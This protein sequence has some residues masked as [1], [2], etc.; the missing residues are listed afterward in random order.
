[1]RIDDTGATLIADVDVHEPVP[2]LNERPDTD[3]VVFN[4]HRTLLPRNYDS[5]FLIEVMTERYQNAARDQWA[6]HSL[7]LMTGHRAQTDKRT[8][9]RIWRASSVAADVYPA[10]IALP[11]TLAHAYAPMVIATA[12]LAICMVMRALAQRRSS[13]VPPYRKRATGCDCSA[14]RAHR[15]DRERTHRRDRDGGRAFPGRGNQHA[16]LDQ[17]RWCRCSRQIFGA[18]EQLTPTNDSSINVKTDVRKY[19]SR[20]ELV[21]QIPMD[22]DTVA[23]PRRPFVVTPEGT[24]YHMKPTREVLLIERFDIQ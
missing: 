21:A 3:E 10:E 14:P 24:L 5:R 6:D 15:N 12:I 11:G 16:R 9:G 8:K 20:G 2:R 7:C 13:V 18:V 23:Q 17:L 19:S 4:V 1:M 22:M